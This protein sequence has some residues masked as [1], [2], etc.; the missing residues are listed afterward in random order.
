MRTSDSL[1]KVKHLPWYLNTKFNYT[2]TLSAYCL[3]TLATCIKTFAWWL[4]QFPFLSSWQFLSKWG[5]S[6]TIAGCEY[7]PLTGGMLIAET[8]GM[9]FSLLTAYME[10]TDNIFRMIQQQILCI[11]D[12]TRPPLGWYDW[13]T[14]TGLVACVSLQAMMHFRRDRAAKQAR[15]SLSEEACQASNTTVVKPSRE[16]LAVGICVLAVVILT[17][18]LCGALLGG[19][20]GQV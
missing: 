20:L 18:F 11:L 16:S 1:E 13:G 5:I 7:L 3:V 17:G 10:V 6:A 2:A 14:A 9:Y 12:N 4:N 19:T 15:E 8:S